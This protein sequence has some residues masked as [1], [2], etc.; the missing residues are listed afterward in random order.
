ML[1]M[2]CSSDEVKERTMLD[3]KKWKESS[4]LPGLILFCGLLAAHFFM[5]FSGDDIAFGKVDLSVEWLMKRYGTWSSRLFIESVLVTLASWPVIVWRVL[6]TCVMWLFYRMIVYYVVPKEQ[7]RFGMWA[8]LGIAILFPIKMLN[9]AGWC[10]TTL[11]YLWPTTAALVA[12]I[13]W[14]YAWEGKPIPTKVLVGSTFLLVF[15]LDFELVLMFCAPLFVLL[16]LRRKSER[17]YR[18]LFVS[19]GVVMLAC[20]LRTA[21]CPGNK[22]RYFK[23]IQHWWPD[24]ASTSLPYKL[25]LSLENMGTMFLF[26]DVM[27]LFLLILVAWLVWHRNENRWLR[28]I[29]LIPVGIKAGALLWRVKVTLGMLAMLP[30]ETAF[31][32]DFRGLKAAWHELPRENH[33]WALH[34]EAAEIPSYLLPSAQGDWMPYALIAASVLFF[35]CLAVSLYAIYGW[36]RESVAMV[37]LYL[38]GCGTSFSMAFSPTLFASSTR[39]FFLNYLALMLIFLHCMLLWKTERR[40]C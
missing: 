38:L 30:Q 11:N 31:H 40:R 6:D 27:L 4:V 35:A 39:I 33:A 14:K 3:W 34:M 18:A 32:M 25:L 5:H 2:C 8:M 37:G 22:A 23:E 7:L 13:P 12:M 36:K 26:R 19:H 15:G 1:K 10:A 17:A 24:Y 28:T 16:F 21:L 9:T 20:F 29:S